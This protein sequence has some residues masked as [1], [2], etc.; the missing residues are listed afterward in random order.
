M[1]LEVLRVA[2][3]NRLVQFIV[4]GAAL[5]ALGG[6]GGGAPT[7]ITLRAAAIDDLT[8]REAQRRG[9]PVSPA[10]RAEVAAVLAQDELLIREAR[11]HGLD[12]DD[13][14]LRQRLVQ[15]MLFVAE[16]LGG[17]SRPL[18]EPEL[19]AYLA[20]HADAYRRPARV[21]I[22]HVV[23]RDLAALAAL[24]PELAAFDRTHPGEIPP[25]GDAL[26]VARRIAATLP[27]LERDWGPAIAG[28]AAV[29]PVG[30]WSDPVRS[31]RGLHLIKLERRD[32]AAAARFE[33]VR[34]E[35]AFD[36]L[37][38]RRE[39]AVARFVAGARA[40]Y[41]LAV[42]DGSPAPLVAPPRT[43]VHAAPS[44]ED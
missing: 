36:A 34:D 18:D 3:R 42:D 30:A 32:P 10:L 22:V 40:R 17:A 33:D 9:S 23:G 14:I 37:R 13:R 8:R 1:W 12:Q 16:D 15:K 41:T 25:F 21:V 6:R 20:A 27:E 31:P 4:L 2:A 44:V 39:A 35:L 11:R 24:R 29:L 26:P 19:R 5:F 43:A 38:A 28:L 7:T